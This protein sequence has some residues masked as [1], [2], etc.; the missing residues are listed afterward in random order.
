ME[1]N[2]LTTLDEYIC[3]LIENY[4]LDV[5]N[6]VYAVNDGRLIEHY[7]KFILNEGFANELDVFLAP[8]IALSEQSLSDKFEEI[9][10]QVSDVVVDSGNKF[11]R[12]FSVNQV[13]LLALSRLFV[14]VCF[15]I[16]TSYLSLSDNHKIDSPNKLNALFSIY[17]AALRTC[18]EVLCLCENGYQ[19]GAYRHGRTLIEYAAIASFLASDTDE[20]SKAFTDSGLKSPRDY[21]SWVLAS[22]KITRKEAKNMS[23]SK[24]IGIMNKRFQDGS[25]SYSMSHAEFRQPY[26][27]K[28]I[29]VHA[30]ARGIRARF[31]SQPELRDYIDAGRSFVGIEAAIT[32]AIQPT[33]WIMYDY[34]DCIQNNETS[35]AWISILNCLAKKIETFSLTLDLKTN[36]I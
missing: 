24:F 5:K 20:V 13:R 7:N 3:D 15:S 22:K 30:S 10:F 25:P 1:E 31:S 14:E 9:L 12:T 6:A 26:N 36:F 18:R 2:K 28:S 23:M 33:C 34:L 35:L 4:R 16:H 29:F 17:G 19:E 32:T 11:R 8:V 27:D 21:Y